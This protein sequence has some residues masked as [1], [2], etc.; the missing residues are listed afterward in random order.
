MIIA[1]R[2]N[3]CYIRRLIC[4]WREGRK[5]ERKREKERKESAIL[6]YDEEL[7]HETGAPRNNAQLLTNL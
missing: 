6:L 3:E 4:D 5:K 1:R 7:S 2:K